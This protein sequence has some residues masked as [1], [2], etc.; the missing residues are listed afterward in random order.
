V[1][2]L[3]PEGADRRNTPVDPVYG[4]YETSG[5]KITVTEGPTTV[6]VV[7]RRPAGGTR[8]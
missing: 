3:P 7:V 1:V 4:R 8:G 6:T 5:I 2:V